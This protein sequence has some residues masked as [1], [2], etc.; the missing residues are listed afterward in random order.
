LVALNVERAKEEATGLVRWL[1]PDYQGRVGARTQQ[2]ALAVK[3]ESED[4]PGKQRAGK[5]AWPETLYERVKAVNTALA[6]VKEPVTALELAKRFARAKAGD[7]GEILETLCA[8]GKARRGKA[9]G[10]FLP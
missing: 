3:V 6:V 4:K 10:T 2:T 9:G 8:V 5:Q 1:R 7:V